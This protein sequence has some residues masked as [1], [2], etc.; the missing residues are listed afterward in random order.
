MIKIDD[1]YKA[2]LL[3]SIEDRMYKLSLDLDKLK[4]QPLTKIRKEL[5]KKQKL[6]EELQHIIHVES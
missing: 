5:A 2:V 4:G 3:E 6:L 1:K